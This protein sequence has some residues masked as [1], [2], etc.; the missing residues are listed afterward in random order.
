MTDKPRIP[1]VLAGRYASVELATLWSPEYKVVLERRLWLAVLKALADLGVAVPPEAVADY[2]RVLERVDLA[3]IAERERVTRHDVKARIEE[4][5]ALAGHEQVHKGMTSRDLTENVE[6]LQIRL[7]LELVRDRAVAVLA[8]LGRLA[9]EYAEL[10]MTGRS[11]N[12]PAQAT[13]LGKRFATAADELLVAL[14]RVEELLARYPLR[15]VKGPVGT[16]QDMLDLLGGDERRLAGL[17]ERI[18]GHLGFGQ[19]FTSVGQVYPRS[20]DYEVVTALVQLAAAPSSLARTIRLM[21]GQELVTEGFQPGQVGSSAMPHKMNTRSCERVNGL[22]VV[23]R[24]YASMTGE[25]AGDQWNEGDVSCSVVRRVALPDAFFA[26]DGLT[27]TF[28]TVLDEFGAFPAV[29]ARELDRYLPFLATTKVLMAAVRAGVGRETAH[30][31]IKEHAVASALRM[32]EGSERNELLDRLAG[33]ERIPLDRAGLD[34]LMTDRLSFTGA[35]A[36]Q[37]AAVRARIEDGVKRHPEAA[38]YV[39]GSIL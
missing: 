25:L 4:F 36:G 39:P 15:G 27:E 6:Q 8:R 33:D 24:G 11:H 1:N 13:T 38:A 26:L 17:E 14:A 29:V 7:S 32:R 3:S 22:A 2:E 30:E 18:A 28:L 35:A 34:A 12:V 20:L 5:N 37:G 21:A 19:V 10:V 9:G 16:S 23:L 31:A